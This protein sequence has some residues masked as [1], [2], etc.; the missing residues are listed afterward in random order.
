[1]AHTLFSFVACQYAKSP[2]RHGGSIREESDSAF[3]KSR[4]PTHLFHFARELC[5][6]VCGDWI[7]IAKE[8]VTEPGN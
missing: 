6:G 1:M 7:V 5:Y 8:A 4:L 3:D 2:L